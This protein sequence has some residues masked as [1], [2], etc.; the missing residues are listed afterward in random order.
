MSTEGHRQGVLVE[1]KASEARRLMQSPIVAGGIGFEWE[2]VFRGPLAIAALEDTQETTWLLAQA[3]AGHPEIQGWDWAHLLRRSLPEDLVAS[4][5][6]VD[7]APNLVPV[8]PQVALPD[9]GYDELAGPS[10]PRPDLN[11]ASDF[12]DPAWPVGA[13]HLREDYTQL[14]R[15]RQRARPEP[16]GRRVRIAGAG[17]AAPFAGAARR[18]RDGLRGRHLAATR[19]DRSA[20]ADGRRT[21]IL[22]RGAEAFGPAGIEFSA[23]PF[24]SANREASPLRDPAYCPRRSRSR[25]PDPK[26]WP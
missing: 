10:G 15:A 12:Q 7:L 9:L 26:R 23:G 4:G 5:A 20:A 14:A 11:C 22:T 13:W 1:V 2:E 21:G 16:G 8:P 18:R 17:P 3:E 19:I 6:I 25:R 24:F